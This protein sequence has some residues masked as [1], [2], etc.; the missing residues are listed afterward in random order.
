MRI[1]VPLVAMV[2]LSA[3]VV[4]AA[5]I[6]S[7]EKAYIEECKGCH[8]MNGAAVA[9]VSKKMQKQGVT[10]RDLRIPEVQAKTDAELKKMITDGTGK[11]EAVKV[12]S[13][14]DVDNVVAFMRTMK[15][16]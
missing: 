8:Q 16:K 2:A 6:K 5:D 9:S 10:M 1:S 15:K 7:G 3:V 4:W 14:A 12:L 11:M 13:A